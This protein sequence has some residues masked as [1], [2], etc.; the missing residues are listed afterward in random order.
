MQNCHCFTYILYVHNTSSMNLRANVVQKSYILFSQIRGDGFRGSIFPRVRRKKQIT[1][2][3]SG[4]RELDVS[5]IKFDIVLMLLLK[6]FRLFFRGIWNS[7]CSEI[8]LSG[9]SG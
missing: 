8:V 5:T 9:F 2:S 4:G 7:V 1:N 3:P 6:R